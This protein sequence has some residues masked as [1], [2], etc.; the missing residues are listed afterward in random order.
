[1]AFITEVIFVKYIVP[2]QTSWPNTNFRSHKFKHIMY[3]PFY[4]PLSFIPHRKTY[5]RLNNIHVTF[6][7]TIRVNL[8][9]KT[10]LQHTH[11]H[12]H[13]SISAFLAMLVTAA[14]YRMMI[15]EASVLPAPLSP[16]WGSEEG[17]SE[18]GK[19]W[20]SVNVEMW[21]DGEGGMDS[22]LQQGISIIPIYSEVDTQGA[23][24]ICCVWVLFFN[25]GLCTFHQD[26]NMILWKSDIPRI[27]LFLHWRLAAQLQ[28]LF[29]RH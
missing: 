20:E 19:E 12:T 14:I 18:D 2:N 28:S 6:H 25:T 3:K 15:F 11:A 1:M 10:V 26:M 22:A 9:V 24:V 27:W 17:G 16:V 4:K 21:E 13:L 29:T 5:G 8:G 23:K 7:W